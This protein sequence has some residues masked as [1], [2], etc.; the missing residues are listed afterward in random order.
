MPPTR[1]SV[2]RPALS[3]LQRGVPDEDDLAEEIYCAYEDIKDTSGENP[4]R[5]AARAVLKLLAAAP[6]IAEQPALQCAVPDG[7]QT[8]VL[9]IAS[10]MEAVADAVSPRN[11]KK[12]PAPY[13]REQARKLRALLA[14]KRGGDRG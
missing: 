2:L 1:S 3:A 12:H 11:G 13:M 4:A 8:E 10:D 7:W 6:V 14:E 5:R 9:A